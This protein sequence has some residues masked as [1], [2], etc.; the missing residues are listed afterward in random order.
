MGALC[1]YEI[2]EK[3][4]L[5]DLHAIHIHATHLDRLVQIGVELDLDVMNSLW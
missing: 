1:S 5:L 3:L 2:K 4:D